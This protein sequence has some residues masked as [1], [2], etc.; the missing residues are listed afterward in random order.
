MIKEKSNGVYNSLKD[1]EF[2][3]E[4]YGTI[5]KKTISRIIRDKF[6]AKDS[7]KRSAKIT[8]VYFEDRSKIEKFL[9]DYKQNH[10]QIKCTEKSESNESNEYNIE[11]L[12]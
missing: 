2:E 8:Y 1:N 11:D 7:E 5:Y 4:N 12:L 3:T 6:G 10:I 9:E